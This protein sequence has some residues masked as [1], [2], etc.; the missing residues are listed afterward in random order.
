MNL[1]INLEESVRVVEAATYEIVLEHAKLEVGTSSAS[2]VHQ[3]T[4]DAPALIFRVYEDAT[5]LGSD[6]GQ[7]A[8]DTPI[9]LGHG[10]FRYGEPFLGDLTPLSLEEFLGEKRMGDQR[11]PVP[12]FEHRFEVVVPVWAKHLERRYPLPIYHS[13]VYRRHGFDDLS[14]NLGN[15]VAYFVAFPWQTIRV[16]NTGGD[17][18]VGGRADDASGIG[19]LPAAVAV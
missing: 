3:G 2:V 13:H 7:G 12:D 11:C 1:S 14:D 17:H 8:D 19:P 4:S 5:N 10:G 15:Q 9:C 6:E 16:R 18:E